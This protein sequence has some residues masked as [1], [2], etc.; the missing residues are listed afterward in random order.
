MNVAA[1]EKVGQ[2]QQMGRIYSSAAA[3]VAWLGEED[4][5]TEPAFSMLKQLAIP[6]AWRSLRLVSASSRAGL[7]SVIRLFQRTYFTRAWIVQEVV[8][9]ARV[10]VL[11]GK[12][13]ID[14]DVLAQAS[15]VFMTTGLRVSMNTMR[16]EQAPAEA[17]VSFSSPTVLRAIKNDREKGQPWYDTLL[18]TLIRTRNFK[19]AN[20]S[21]KLYSLLGLIQQH[22]QNKALLRPEYEVQS[23]ET[24]Y[25]NAAIQILTESDDLLLLSC[26]EGELFQHSESAEPM[27]SWVPDWREEKPLGLR[28]TGYARYWAAGEELTQ[29]PVIDRLAS[30]LTLKGL[31]LDEI[32]RTGETKYEVFGSGPPSFPGWADILTSLPPSYRGMRR[33]TD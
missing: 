25:K 4:D 33:D 7:L 2:I 6:G 27:P 30:T 22:V 10:M 12:C 17:D 19:S 20:P 5:D 29:R 3:V 31:K 32:S 15:H 21:D 1:E 23:T 14:W 9:A 28:G 11:C 26:V 18:H 13:E 24:T 8:L 16:K